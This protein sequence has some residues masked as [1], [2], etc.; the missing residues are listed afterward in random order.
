MKPDFFPV[1]PQDVYN[2]RINV[3]NGFNKAVKFDM[4]FPKGGPKCPQNLSKWNQTSPNCNIVR[5]FFPRH[6]PLPEANSTQGGNPLEPHKTNI[7]YL[8]ILY[9]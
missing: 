2:T 3:Q 6:I 8:P 7:L 4:H 5:I 1:V 9:F